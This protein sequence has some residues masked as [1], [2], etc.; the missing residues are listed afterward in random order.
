MEGRVH[1]SVKM[2]PVE[3][4]T[5]VNPRVRN[6]KIFKDIV[7]NIAQLGL[8]RPITV[9][10]HDDSRWTPLRTGLRPGPT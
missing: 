2:I 1:Q 9:T 6:K 4:I 7:T 8:K 5:V 10:K 3:R